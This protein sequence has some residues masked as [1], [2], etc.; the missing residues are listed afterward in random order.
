MSDV[1]RPVLEWLACHDDIAIASHLDP[2]GDSLGSSLALAAALQHGG[3]RVQVIIGQDLPERFAWLPGAATVRAVADLPPEAQAAIL[4]ECSDFARCGVAGIDRVPS[5]N[6]DHHTKNHRFAQ[7][8]WLDPGVAAT[9]MMIELLIRALNAPLTADIAALLYVTVLTDTGSFNHSNTD[10]AAL[11]FAARMVEAGADPERVAE[12]VYGHVAVGRVR[13]MAA[14]LATLEMLESGQVAVMDI[15]DEVF[16]QHGSR[17]TEGLINIAQRI[18]GVR[19]SIL[20]KEAEDGSC[21]VSLRSDGGVDVAE[22]AASCGGGGHPRAAGMS[23]PGPLADGRTAAVDLA[24]R[25]LRGT[26]PG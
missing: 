18:E 20:V 19:I 14:A 22:L 13:V 2:D 8:N 3:K 6:I 5:L 16:R 11:T 21:R 23:M 17:D 1:P 24:V 7:V 4:V 26:L 25:A 9:G 12:E 10:A 15:A